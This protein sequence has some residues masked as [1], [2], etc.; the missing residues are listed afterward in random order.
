MLCLLPW[1]P[2]WAAAPLL[3]ESP[4][5][6]QF[7]LATAVS[8]YRDESGTQDWEAIQA[9]PD[10]AWQAVQ[11]PIPA[12]GFDTTPYWFRFTIQNRSGAAF[13]GL[14][15]IAYPI[16][17]HVALY[18]VSGPEPSQPLQLGDTLPFHQR[19]LDHHNFAIPLPLADGEERRFLLRV[20]TE[21]S[22]QV[23]L[24]LWERDA[25]YKARQN[26]LMGH[27]LYFG[28][29][30]VMTL[31][32]L[33]I[34]ITV[35][36]PSYIYYALS[37][38]G[39]GLFMAALH[40]F[41]YQ[42][43]WPTLPQANQW[44][45]VASL[46]FF[47]I[48]ACAFTISLL[49]LK[50]NS[51]RYYRLLLAHV[52]LYVLV[53]VGAFLMPYKLAILFAIVVG[54]TAC[55]SALLSGG[56]TL[57]RGL[58]EA[59]YYVLAYGSLMV[60]SIIISLNKVGIV[61]RNFFTENSMQISSMM[62]V[63]LLSF[64]LADRINQERRKKYEAQKRALENEKLAREERER[65]LK[66]EFNAQ[67]DELNSQKKII[68]AEAESR[69]KS[70]FLATMSHEIRTP[71]N[72][73][74]GMA[75]LLQDTEL[76]PQQQQYLKVINSSGKAL[77]NI[78]NDV[79]DYSKIS[80]GKM[81]LEQIDIELE[82][83]L[84]ECVSVFFVS[85]ERKQ[86]AL[87][88]ETQQGVP[89]HVLGDPT[90]LRQILLNLLG[91]AFKFT[92]HGAVTVT[93]SVID[94][95]SPQLQFEVKDTGIGI[96]AAI[97]KNLFNPFVQADSTTTRQF[98]GTGLGLTISQRL[99]ELMSGQISVD[100]QEGHGSRFRFHIPL[101][102][103]RAD[104]PPEPQDN[105]QQEAIRRYRVILAD[106]SEAFLEVMQRQ[107]RQEGLTLLTASTTG[108]LT[109]HCQATADD[110]DTVLLIGHQLADASGLDG[111]R[112][113]Q[114]QGLARHCR[115]LLLAPMRPRPELVEL[116]SA[117]VHHVI[118]QPVMWK[119]LRDTLS[120]LHQGRLDSPS[121]ELAHRAPTQRH[122]VLVAEDNQVNQMVV[123]KML[124]K[125]G[126][127]YELADNGRHALDLLLRDYDR[128]DAVLMDCEMPVMDGYEATR[129]LRQQETKLQQ[130]HKPVIALTAHVL[131]EHK[132]KAEQAG[133]DDFLCKPLGYQ[134]LE[135]KLTRL[136]PSQQEPHSAAGL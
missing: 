81:H 120:D 62:E 6:E 43:L 59:R 8:V 72:G 35:R 9:L 122:R 25:F 58:R 74:L 78:I 134:A 13:D 56:Y 63:I 135:E 69:A 110:A 71:M 133:M 46:G 116:T 45:L 108:E 121:P 42:Y 123:S 57:Y 2:A 85:A 15:E 136:L 96:P 11:T 117:G 18:E 125:M 91:N 106:R 103:A 101:Q 107:A 53:F 111:L 132:H 98:G 30:I 114:Q 23:P 37:V 112:Q 75:E 76:N 16:L 34:F 90:R 31:Y 21:S 64:A 128:F 33:F 61:P 29:L 94:Q 26:T 99:V 60:A 113:L 27:G 52:I 70:E 55:V 17:D 83:L 66:V 130:S 22:V 118:Q 50:K 97:S 100:S 44:A 54:L 84:L 39:I 129:L 79:L 51:P 5:Q 102:Q 7:N 89:G 93:V 126:L 77:L 68:E 36:H 1:T 4:H 48:F 124:D 73:V 105:P 82:T 67:V 88:V 49:H 14:L 87:L 20:E 131:S 92:Q 38:T 127:E 24:Y 41:G 10:A 115:R 80:A 28:M 40:G 32:N 86:L 119:Q 47:G 65:Y 104:T 12:F 19:P 109:R 3:I 95:E